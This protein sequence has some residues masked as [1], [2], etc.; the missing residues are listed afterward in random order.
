MVVARLTPV[1]TTGVISNHNAGAHLLGADR[2][3]QPDGCCLR[4]SFW[5][6]SCPSLEDSVRGHARIEN[7]VGV[8]L[9][10]KIF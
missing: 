4:D 6:L 10:A 5:G 3:R 8:F 7:M 2:D 9:R 1:S